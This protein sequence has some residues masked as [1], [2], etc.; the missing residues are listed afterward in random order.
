MFGGGVYSSAVAEVDT[1]STND[2]EQI[3]RREI[4]EAWN[5]GDDTVI[6]E[7]MTDDFSYHNPMV[8]EEIHGP[9]A[10]KSL[11][12]EYR[13]AVDEF[14][15]TV[16]EMVVDDGSVATRFTTRGIHSKP[17]RGVEPT[18]NEIEVTG[19]MIDHIE[20]G[21]IKERYVNDDALGLEKQLGVVPEDV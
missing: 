4:E 11:I 9:E 10:Y 3:V 14:E 6:G 13:D 5:S 8:T 19:I 7:L 2:N 18:G 16:E 17:L 12:D 20:N 21:K 1:M 15:M